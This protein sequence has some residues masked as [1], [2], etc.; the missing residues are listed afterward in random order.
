AGVAS[1]DRQVA[2]VESTGKNAAADAAAFSGRLA[3]L[4]QQVETRQA[5]LEKL[6]EEAS[7]KELEALEAAGRAATAFA[8]GK[9][10]VDQRS[11]AAREIQSSSD[12]KNANERLRKIM[13][14][15]ELKPLPSA[16]EADART[17]LGWIHFERFDGFSRY[18]A[19][20]SRLARLFPG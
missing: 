8:G 1:I 2:A 17:L 14:D 15:A 4:K 6:A 18:K 20:L 5:E 12:P 11:R 3:E 7:H 10:A 16:G 9:S 13:S 19:D